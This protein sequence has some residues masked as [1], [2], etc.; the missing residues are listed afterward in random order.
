MTQL[1]TE[2]IVLDA[3]PIGNIVADLS[4]IGGFR[5]YTFSL[6]NNPGNLF[7]LSGTQIAVSG[8]LTIGTTSITI[9]ASPSSSFGAVIFLV[10]PFDVIAT[11]PVWVPGQRPF[12]VNSIINLPLGTNIPLARLPWAPYTPGGG[13]AGNYVASNR[14]TFDVPDATAP[15]VEVTGLIPGAWGNPTFTPNPIPMTPGFEGLPGVPGDD[16]IGIVIYNNVATEFH[17]LFRTDDN[18]AT[19]LYYGQANVLSN[20]GFGYANHSGPNGT[21]SAGPVATGSSVF[22]GAFL[23]QE[24][25]AF[26]G[27]IQHALNVVIFGDYC[28]LGPFGPGSGYPP[29]IAGD[30]NRTIGFCTEGQFLA[31]PPGVSMPAGLSAPY[32][33]LMF[34]AAQQ[35]GMFINDTGGGTNINMGYAPVGPYAASSWNSTDITNLLADAG[36]I[37]PLLCKVGF[38][39]DA[40]T[41]IIYPWCFCAPQRS[42]LFANGTSNILQ[43]TRDFDSTSINVSYT[44][45]DASGLL[46]TAQIAA[47]C[48]STTG[49]VTQY[50]TQFF[51][52]GQFN[53][54]G[55]A[56]PI[57]YQSNALVTMGGQ[58]ALL[59][60]GATNYMQDT[61]ALSILFGLPPYF[62]F[63]IQIADYSANYALLGF[64]VSGGLELRVDASTGFLHLLNNTGTSIVICSLLAL[65]LNTP[66]IVELVWQVNTPSSGIS[67]YTIW[68]NGIQI[69]FGTTTVA[70]SVT[71]QALIGSGGPGGVDLFKGIIGQWAI[72]AQPQPNPQ[73]VIQQY[74]FDFWEASVIVITYALDNFTDTNGTLLPAHTMDIGT[75]WTDLVGSHWVQSNSAQPD[76]LVS[77]KAISVFSGQA[78]GHYQMTITPR[79]FESANNYKQG[80]I[81]RCSDAN[82]YCFVQ[83]EPVNARVIIGT[84]QGGVLSY[85]GSGESALFIQNGVPI[86]LDVFFNGSK[87]SF[88]WNGGA[89]FSQTTTFNQNATLVGIVTTISGTP[90]T[91]C[92]YDTMSLKS[93]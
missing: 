12:T 16:H 72:T 35:Y 38:V 29:A 74:A 1:I 23:K 48:P 85:I 90:A 91:P 43:V 76:T 65:P 56:A 45:A 6:T 89:V 78:N 26:P 7:S 19:A 21:Q 54:A 61:V 84:V 52:S 49:R 5:N 71:G 41:T 50:F 39:L 60:D 82:N 27:G 31:I 51:G 42:A 3:V 18:D 37:I 4:I 57:I 30:G 62:I 44:T 81:F 40:F 36:L 63:A 69:A 75:G 64:N 24:C 79:G 46:N 70:A 17:G 92:S 14:F 73:F 28:N 20:D 10:I 33:Q 93:S 77:N 66:L 2:T 80:L 86:V 22:A 9:E 58:P 25:D 67:T 53:S 32:G 47:F 83:V 13:A 15:F 59:F 87:I 8:E 55:S 88:Q 11:A 68:V 34:K